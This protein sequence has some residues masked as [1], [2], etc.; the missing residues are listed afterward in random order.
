MNDSL[1]LNNSVAGRQVAL[2]ARRLRARPVQC[3]G[4]ADTPPRAGAQ[5]ST[6]VRRTA[7][8]RT[9]AQIDR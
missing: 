5:T 4:G 2:S 1:S 8:R 9:A 7:A 3:P 6:Q